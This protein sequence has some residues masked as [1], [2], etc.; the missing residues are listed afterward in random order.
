MRGEEKLGDTQRVN[1]QRVNSQR[2]NSQR[3]NSQRVVREHNLNE[4]KAE[5]TRDGRLAQKILARDDHKKLRKRR[6]VGHEK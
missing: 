2:V 4:S 6:V 3:V 5:M 1:T